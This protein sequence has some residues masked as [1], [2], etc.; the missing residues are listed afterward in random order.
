MT[1]YHDPIRQANYIQ[2]SLSQDKKPIGIFL[3]AGC[4]TLGH[5]TMYE[6]CL[7]PDEPSEALERAIEGLTSDLLLPKLISCEAD[8]EN[9]EV[10]MTNN[11]S[12][13]A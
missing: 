6:I 8:V 1:E 7:N 12:G 9:I 3:S 13:G 4:G 11:G 5:K 2:Q 10:Q